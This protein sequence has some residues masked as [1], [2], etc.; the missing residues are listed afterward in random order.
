MEPATQFIYLLFGFGII[1]IVGFLLLWPF[2]IWG[3]IK[4]QTGLLEK[5]F[6]NI[7]ESKVNLIVI[8]EELQAQNRPSTASP[9]Q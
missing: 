9:K 5:I 8:R 2:I 6:Q 3:H 7:S 4:K 1:F